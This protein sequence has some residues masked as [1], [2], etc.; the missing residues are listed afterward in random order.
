MIAR[1]QQL[2]GKTKTPN[3]YEIAKLNRQVRETEKEVWGFRAF[4]FI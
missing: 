4:E 3:I 1:I 2:L